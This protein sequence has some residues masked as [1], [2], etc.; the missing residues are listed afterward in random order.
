MENT[1]HDIINKANS[2][3]NHAEKLSFETGKQI[4]VMA[5][6]ITNLTNDYIHTGTE[7]VKE[8]PVKVVAIAAAAGAVVGSLITIFMSR[9]K[10]I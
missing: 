6:D 2:V 9:R 7:Y 5:S 10:D 8:N 3:I 4:G 1:K